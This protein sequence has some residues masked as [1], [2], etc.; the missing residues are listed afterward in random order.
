MPT[1][2]SGSGGA[3]R[4]G[5]L[6]RAVWRWHF[7]AGLLLIPFVLLLATTGGLYL[8]KPQIDAALDAP[9]RDLMSGPHI[10]ADAEIAAALATYPRASLDAYVLP[11][12]AG[13][14]GQVLLTGSDGTRRVYVDPA[15][16]R[17]LASV[18]EESRPTELLRR[19]HGTL[20]VGTAGSVLVELAASWAF[21]MLATGLYLWWPRGR[22]GAAGLLYPRRGRL[23]W[24]DLHAVTGVWVSGFALLLLLTALP[25]TTVW[26]EG[27]KRTRALVEPPR[28]DWSAG[29]PRDAHAGHEGH[30]IHRAAGGAVPLETIVA[31]VRP[32]GLGWPVHVMQARDGV[33][34]AA[35]LSQRPSERATL[36]FDAATGRLLSRE[37]LADKPAISRVVQLGI[38]L[39]EGQLFGLPNQ[40][41]GLATALGL[42][43]LCV[44]A[45]VLWWRRRPE[46]GLGA[47]PA[48][49]D[50]RLAGGLALLI[51]AL[52]LFLPLLGAS[53]LAVALVERLLLRRWRAAAAW[54]GLAPRPA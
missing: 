13:D 19:I 50:A 45:V 1:S 8:F 12:S 4:A 37:T 33:V 24:R 25:W 40:L 38:A 10:G 2:A 28:Q 31:Q 30:A 9:Y 32:L 41:L 48:L 21:V 26:G 52:A 46:Q 39:H 42:I 54:L 29:F 20:L 17:V 16:G 44:S 47:P 23:F 7:Y 43:A 36:R 35:G 18:R 22:S 11:R 3:A 27:F 49:P 14:A 15:S 5:A 6:Y 53:L 34:V 51:G